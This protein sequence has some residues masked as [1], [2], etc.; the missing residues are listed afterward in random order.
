M[1]L[2]LKKRPG[3]SRLSLRLS[4]LSLRVPWLRLRLPGLGDGLAVPHARLSG[5]AQPLVVLGIS[6][7]GIEWDATDGQPA[8]LIFLVLTA[9]HDTNSQ[10]QILAAIARALSTPEVSRSLMEADNPQDVWACLSAH[11]PKSQTEGS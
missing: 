3:L 9:E 7:E 1:A 5:L 4:R 2:F 6:A 11:L 8:H 10:L